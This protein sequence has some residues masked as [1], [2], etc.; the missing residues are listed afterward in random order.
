[1]SFLSPENINQVAPYKVTRVDDMSVSFVTADGVRYLIGF[2][3][4]IFV[5]DKDGYY[6]Y[7]VDQDAPQKKDPLI[8]KTIIAIIEDFFNHVSQ[9]AVLYI[10]DV[11]DKK[12]ALRARLFSGWFNTADGNTKYT[13]NTYQN[14]DDKGVEYYYGLILRKDNPEHDEIVRI[15]Y[16]FLAEH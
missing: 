14:Q 16:D 12:Q 4:D 7:V 2:F 5:V 13:L 10:C 6:L 9:S 1:M 3:H 15:F 11:N 8:G